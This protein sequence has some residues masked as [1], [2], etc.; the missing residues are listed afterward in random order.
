[1]H[2]TAII[3]ARTTSTRLPGKILKELPLDSGITVLEQVI[4]RVKH[5]HRIENLIVA[6]TVDK[7][8]DSVCDIAKKE[9]V[10]CFR[11]DRDD[12]LSRYY[13]AAKSNKADVIVRITS[14]CPCVD[15]GVTDTIIDAHL[16]SKR[17]YTSNTLKR[18]YPRGLDTEV[19]NFGVLEKAYKGAEDSYEREHVTPHIYRNPEVFKVTNIE[20]PPELYAPDVRVTL[21]TKGDYDLLCRIF[22][23]LYTQNEFF[24][25]YEIVNF[26]KK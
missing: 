8:D 19:F 20:A 7:A 23:N 3:Q 9:G 10:K 5:S 2:I 17:D 22:E 16:E 26:L 24:T 14:D 13:R 1:M 11:G 15:A 4:R 12:V 25:A 21:D 6:T 18:T